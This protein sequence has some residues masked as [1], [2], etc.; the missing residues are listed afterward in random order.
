M[1][2]RGLGALS[3]HLSQLSLVLDA[4]S[5]IATAVLVGQLSLQLL[6]AR[7]ARAVG[8]AALQCWLNRTPGLALMLAIGESA[9]RDERF[10][11]FERRLQSHARFAQTELAHSGRIDEQAAPAALSFCARTL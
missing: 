9:V 7:V 3:K 4:R 8:L 5:L 1:G 11:V 6:I 10:D 2:A